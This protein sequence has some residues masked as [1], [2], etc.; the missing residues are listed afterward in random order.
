MASLSN[1]LHCGKFGSTIAQARS[2]SSA[3]E[4][5]RVPVKLVPPRDP[6]IVYGFV[7]FAWIACSL[8]VKLQ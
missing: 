1:K 2:V 5:V 6:E 8:Q 7:R 3:I 4:T